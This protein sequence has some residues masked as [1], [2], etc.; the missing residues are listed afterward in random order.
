MLVIEARLG[1]RSTKRIAGI[2][3]FVLA[4]GFAGG[5]LTIVREY[6]HFLDQRMPTGP[7]ATVDSFLQSAGM[8]TSEEFLSGIAQAELPR[9]A[10]VAF[11][12]PV[13]GSSA[14]SFWQTYYI[15]GY[16]LT[17]RPV[18]VIA[19]CE[20]PAA[21]ATTE[22]APARQNC[23]AFPAVTDL[24]A[25]VAARGAHHVLVA[26]TRDVPLDRVRAHRVSSLL[27]LLDLR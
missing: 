10:G 27:T 18:W 3:A 4:I 2:T 21:A 17:P 20:A 19:W 23:E 6:R 16:L 26:G 1:A 15:A 24:P 8:G 22:S 25:A 9:D 13:S 14:Q 7:S 5:A 12:V 11:V